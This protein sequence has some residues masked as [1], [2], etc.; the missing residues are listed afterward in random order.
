[1]ALWQ[2]YIP[3]VSVQGPTIRLIFSW[4]HLCID[5]SLVN[6]PLRNVHICWQRQRRRSAATASWRE[7]RSVTVAGRTNVV[8]SAVTLRHPH[9]YYHHHHLRQQQGDLVLVDLA[10]SAG[11]QRCLHFFSQRFSWMFLHYSLP[12]RQGDSQHAVVFGRLCFVV[13]LQLV[14]LFVTCL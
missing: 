5:Y 3:N 8:K 9:H 7:T 6:M 14:C 1:M 11:L 2:L 4:K 13:C 12:R 10:P